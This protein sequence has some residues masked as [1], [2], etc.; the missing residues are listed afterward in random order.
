MPERQESPLCCGF[1]KKIEKKGNLS[2]VQTSGLTHHT[3]EP[4][5]GNLANAH[6]G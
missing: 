4:T 5:K 1:Y 6:Q 3:M 2:N